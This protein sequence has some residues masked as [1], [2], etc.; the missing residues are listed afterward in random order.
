[1]VLVGVVVFVGVLVGVAPGVDVGVGV[2]V[3]VWVV[4]GDG[5]SQTK[6]SNLSHPV[7]SVISKPTAGAVLNWG[8]NVNVTGVVVTIS[9]K[10]H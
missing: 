2:G 10:T 1:V 9:I 4:V 6:I 3:G 7:E 5:I 8:G